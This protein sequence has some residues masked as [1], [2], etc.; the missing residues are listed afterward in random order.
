MPP[1]SDI[2][3]REPDNVVNAAGRLAGDFVPFSAK[4]F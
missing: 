2:L 3:H 1:I 4:Y